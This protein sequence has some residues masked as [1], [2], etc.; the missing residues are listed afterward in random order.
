MNSSPE[1]SRKIILPESCQN[2]KI[3]KH[4]PERGQLRKGPQR[5]PAS[6]DRQR[7][8]APSTPQALEADP[9]QTP[10]RARQD[11]SLQTSHQKDKRDGTDQLVTSYSVRL[12]I[13]QS[14][15]NSARAAPPDE[16]KLLRGSIISAKPPARSASETSGRTGDRG[17]AARERGANLS[18][19]GAGPAHDVGITWQETDPIDA[20][21]KLNKRPDRWPG[22]PRRDA[23]DVADLLSRHTI[24]GIARQRERAGRVHRLSFVVALAFING[25]GGAFLF[26]QFR[27]AIFADG[28]R[29]VLLL[30]SIQQGKG[31]RQKR[32]GPLFLRFSKK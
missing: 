23:E 21:R 31:L 7:R 19:R 17:S 30:I 11:D 10:E 27:R 15:D 13:G 6:I 24:N 29:D 12:Y 9:E 3:K 5:K 22:S 32:P 2:C 20:R 28:S 1:R 4:E 26:C 16:P 8:R 18:R 25:S 14:G